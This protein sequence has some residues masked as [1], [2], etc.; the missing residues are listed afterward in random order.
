MK[1]SENNINN[2]KQGFIKFK[3]LLVNHSSYLIGC[4]YKR[5]G[6]LKK[7]AVYIHFYFLIS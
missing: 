6:T 1:S 7:I 3:P 2:V 4:K 5:F